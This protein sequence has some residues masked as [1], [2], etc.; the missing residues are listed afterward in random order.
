MPR[1]RVEIEYL[2]GVEDP[3][4]ETVLRNLRIIGFENVSDV[5]ISKSFEFNLSGN[6]DEAIRSVKDIADKLLYNPVIQKFDIVE[7]S[8]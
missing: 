2:D 3:E 4:S 8:D 1:V 7:I 6:R 5:K